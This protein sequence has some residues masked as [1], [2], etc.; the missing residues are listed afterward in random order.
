MNRWA[1]ML[2]IVGAGLALVFHFAG[3]ASGFEAVLTDGSVILI[4]VGVISG[5]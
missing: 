3:I 2:G 1:T 5:Y 4:G